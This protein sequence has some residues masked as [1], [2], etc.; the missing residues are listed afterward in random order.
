MKSFSIDLDKLDEKILKILSINGSI[1]HRKIAKSLNKSP[2]T[3]SKRIKEL[4]LKGVIKGYTVN[5]DYEKL[6]YELIAFIELTI[7]KGRMLE[8]ENNL[9]KNPHVFG[10]YDITGSYDAIIFARFKTR[11]ELSELI[12]IINTYKYIVRT[13][14]HII[15][16]TIKNETSLSDLLESE[17]SEKIPITN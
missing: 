14:T 9:S 2:V 4:E 7:S 1:S 5:I 15:L 6:G 16:N 10:V 17:K 3:I 11:S 8:I 12:K 13:N